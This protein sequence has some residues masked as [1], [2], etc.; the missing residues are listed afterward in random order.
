MNGGTNRNHDS[1]PSI[2]KKNKNKK[3]EIFANI[4]LNIL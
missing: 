2:K 3:S 4:T 1:I